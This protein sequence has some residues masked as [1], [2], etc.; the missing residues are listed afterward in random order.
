[1]KDMK[2]NGK[3]GIEMRRKSDFSKSLMRFLNSA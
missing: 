2:Q 1:M 3:E